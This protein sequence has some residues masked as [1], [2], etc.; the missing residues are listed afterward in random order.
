MIAGKRI[1]TY[2]VTLEGKVDELQ[3]IVNFQH[4]RL[5]SLQ[6]EVDS[7]KQDR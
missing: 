4:G 2:V 5:A 6:E 1:R 7:F 3:S